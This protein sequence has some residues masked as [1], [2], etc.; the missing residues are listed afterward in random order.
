MP[1]VILRYFSVYGPRQR[2]DMGYHQFIR[3]MLTGEAITVTGDGHQIR[4]NTYVGDCVAATVAAIDAMPGEIFNVGGG[5][6]ASVWDVL[7]RLGSD[8]RRQGSDKNQTGPPR[9]PTTYLRGYNKTATP[10][11][12]AADH[13]AR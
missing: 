6:M 5:E 9:R 8:R 7:Q 4:G 10:S 13:R 11:G 12:V 2:P 1:L 3:A